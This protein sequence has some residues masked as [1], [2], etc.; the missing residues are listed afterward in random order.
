M[1]V[2]KDTLRFFR[3]RGEFRRWLHRNHS[4]ATELWLGM[5]RKDSGKRGITYPEALE[6]AL[7]YGWIDGIRKKLDDA[8]FATRFTPRK[9]GSVWSKVNVGHV[10]RLKAEGRMHES[11]LAAYEAKDDARSGVYSFEREA[12]DLDAAAK[13]SFSRNR[14]AWKYFQAQPPYYRR[15]A[16]WWVISAKREETR[17]RRLAQLIECSAQQERLPPFTSAQGSKNK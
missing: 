16:S 12:A 11:G 9:R 1:E 4:K 5:Y 13:N 17:N 6:E 15:L 2:R 3:S 7:C 8:S 10:E 14:E